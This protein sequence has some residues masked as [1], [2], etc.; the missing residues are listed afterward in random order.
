MVVEEYQT[1]PIS[2]ADQLVPRDKLDVICEYAQSEYI[3]DSFLSAS[4]GKFDLNPGIKKEF[5]C[6]VGELASCNF[7][8]GASCYITSSNNSLTN[9]CERSDI[10][11]TTGGEILSIEGIGDIFLR[12][13]SDSDDFMS[14][15]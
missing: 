7:D 15:C 11:T 4:A 6:Q 9:Y 8:D 14:S 3:L 1:L 10:V 5:D 12:F 13:R 2:V